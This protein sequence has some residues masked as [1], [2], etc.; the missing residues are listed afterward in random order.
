M[1][2]EEYDRA[3]G[4]ID[5]VLAILRNGILDSDERE[6]KA[7]AI[8]SGSLEAVRGVLLKTQAHYSKV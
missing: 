7:L 6:G 1:T 8:I 5:D 3:T 2:R 4:T